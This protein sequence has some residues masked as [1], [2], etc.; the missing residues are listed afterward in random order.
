MAGTMGAMALGD[1]PRRTVVYGAAL[2][3]AAMG[4]QTARGDVVVQ[5]R[6]ADGPMVLNQPQNYVLKNVAK[7]TKRERH[8]GM[9]SI[10]P[11][12]RAKPER[13]G[14]SRFWPS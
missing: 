10:T 7:Q 5:D 4:W 12:L 14:C 3:V 6:I 1:H 8:S 2:I 13:P 9:Q 11:G